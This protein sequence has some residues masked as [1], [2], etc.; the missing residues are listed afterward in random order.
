MTHHRVSL[1]YLDMNSYFASV[2]QQEDPSLRG[3]PLGVVTTMTPN[4]AIIAASTEAKALGLKFGA[5]M[6][7]AR[8]MVPHMQFRPARHDLYVD[9]HHQIK[10]A[11]ERVLPITA[12]HSVDEFS[13]HLR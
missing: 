12:A 11:V 9:Y 6:S 3:Q 10:A 1:L 2:E 13:I 4:A 7:K 5:R 8:Q